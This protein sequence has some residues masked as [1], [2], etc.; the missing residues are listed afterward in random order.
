M[1]EYL[2]PTVLLYGMHEPRRLAAIRAYLRTAGIR[3]LEVPDTDWEQSLG[4]L[5][6]RPGFARSP[7]ALP[8]PEPREEMLVMFAFRGRMLGELLQFFRDRGLRP[9]SLKAM[10][11][12]TN[13][14]WSGTRL[15]QELRLE[16]AA[17]ESAKKREP[18]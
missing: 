15:Q 9:V 11:T 6:E 2:Q 18:I 4:A 14:C 13:V 17:I 12:D 3:A 16:R 8:G 1:T 5:L 7:A 10:V